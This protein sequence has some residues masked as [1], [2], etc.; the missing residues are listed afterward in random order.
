MPDEG[1]GT[2]AFTQSVA[3][4]ISCKVGENGDQ[5]KSF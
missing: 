5:V 4:V 2:D 3:M 1:A